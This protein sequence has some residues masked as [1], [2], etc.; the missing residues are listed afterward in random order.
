MSK[1]TNEL[2]RS[3]FGWSTWINIGGIESTPTNN[4]LF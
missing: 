4:F 1:I 2:Y 3:S